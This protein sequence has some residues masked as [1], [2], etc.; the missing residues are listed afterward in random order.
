MSQIVEVAPGAEVQIM[1]K[2]GPMGAY[3]GCAVDPAL[4]SV[5]FFDDGL[6]IDGQLVEARFKLQRK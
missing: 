4:G 5:A 2:F 6:G 1:R 3:R